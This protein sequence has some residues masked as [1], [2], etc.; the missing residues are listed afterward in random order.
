M[1]KLVHDK[2]PF[3]HVE[4]MHVHISTMANKAPIQ[5]RPG[6]D[7]EVGNNHKNHPPGIEDPTYGYTAYLHAS[8]HRNHPFYWTGHPKRGEK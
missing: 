2:Q 4:D 5:T 3:G 8:Q 6:A 1:S 7:M